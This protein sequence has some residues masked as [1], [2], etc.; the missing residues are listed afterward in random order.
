[1]RTN[2]VVAG[3]EAIRACLGHGSLAVY[4]L[5]VLTACFPVIFT[6]VI[7]PAPSYALLVTSSL[8]TAQPIE[9]FWSSLS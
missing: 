6:D 5:A 7:L 1:M 2:F 3:S 9:V 8:A 4:P